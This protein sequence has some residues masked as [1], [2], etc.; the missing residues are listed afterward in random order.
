MAQP[1]PATF[2]QTQILYYGMFIGQAFMA[3]VIFYLMQE[4]PENSPVSP[5]DIIIPGAVVMGFAVSYFIGQQRKNAIPVNGS[6]Q[7]K[8]DHYRTT[9]I[10]KWALLEGGN[11]ISLVLTFATANTNYLL[12]F[13][14]GLAAFVLLRPSKDKFMEEYQIKSGEDFA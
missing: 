6:M 7:E 3:L 1:Q 4:G 12:W 14:L 10:I 2:K 8:L 5:F 9:N 13:G 11:L